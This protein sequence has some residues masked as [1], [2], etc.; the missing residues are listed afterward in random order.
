MGPVGRLP[1]TRW[2]RAIGTVL[3]VL[4][5]EVAVRV[6]QG[7]CASPSGSTARENP[8]TLTGRPC[9]TENTLDQTVV[10]PVGKSVQMRT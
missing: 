6:A 2:G 9:P 4:G 8:S 5:N 7:S 3:S 10:R 1:N